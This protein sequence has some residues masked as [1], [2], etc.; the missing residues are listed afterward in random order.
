MKPLRNR[1]APE[2]SR[3]S[4]SSPGRWPRWR[5][6]SNKHWDVSDLCP[7]QWP[8][9]LLECQLTP[10]PFAP[11]SRAPW[12]ALTILHISPTKTGMSASSPIVSTQFPLH[13]CPL[14]SASPP[15]LLSPFLCSHSK[16]KE[17]ERAREKR[18]FS[19]KR[20]RDERLPTHSAIA[21]KMGVMHSRNESGTESVDFG[22]P[23]HEM[24][25]GVR[26]HFTS[27]HDQKGLNSSR[28]EKTNK[29]AVQ[30]KAWAMN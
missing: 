27:M 26:A 14:R 21:G 20:H 6:V 28:A 23:T 17:G 18:L 13:R 15:L 1:K 29:E 3:A 2:S 7:L 11:T 30:L 9:M 25:G 4:G 12:V 19:C 10:S 22:T 5:L 16:P 8:R 24:R